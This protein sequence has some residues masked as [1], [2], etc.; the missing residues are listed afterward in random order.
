MDF[1]ATKSYDPKM[2]LQVPGE[3]PKPLKEP[4]RELMALVDSM[5]GQVSCSRIGSGSLFN[6]LFCFG[7]VLFLRLGERYLRPVTLL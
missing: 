2:E 3:V 4:D 5:L 7:V 1:H 6:F